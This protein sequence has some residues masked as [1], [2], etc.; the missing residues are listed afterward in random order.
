MNHLLGHWLFC[1]STCFG[2]SSIPISAAALTRLPSGAWPTLAVWERLAELAMLWNELAW[3]IEPPSALRREILSS[4]TSSNEGPS[5]NVNVYEIQYNFTW[6]IVLMFLSIDS[7]RKLTWYQYLIRNCYKLLSSEESIFSIFVPLISFLSSIGRIKQ[8]L[9][10]ILRS[11]PL[12]SSIV[13]QMKMDINPPLQIPYKRKQVDQ[14]NWL[15]PP[16]L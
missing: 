8:P 12:P 3:R 14:W 4:T 5:E 6:W 13:T 15:S 10:S 7:W 1:L 11:H 16:L 9:P 2:P